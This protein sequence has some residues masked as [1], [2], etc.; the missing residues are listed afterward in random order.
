MPI[1]FSRGVIVVDENPNDITEIRT[2]SDAPLSYNTTNQTY[3]KFDVTQSV[4]NRWIAQVNFF[5]LPT[6]TA[7]SVLFSNGTTISQDNTNFF[8]NDS[9]NILYANMDMGTF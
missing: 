1:V 3:Y 4:G 7:G 9:T 6:L 8:Y 2:T 5:V